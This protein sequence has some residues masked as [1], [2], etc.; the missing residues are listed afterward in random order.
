MMVLASPSNSLT[1]SH[2]FSVCREVSNTEYPKK[3]F[4]QR[5]VDHTDL[6]HNDQSL[7]QQD[8]K[9]LGL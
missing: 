2:P 7:G 3:C 9:D 1:S 8:H 4:S 5:V 6:H